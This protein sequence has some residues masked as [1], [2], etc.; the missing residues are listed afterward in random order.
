[1]KVI[2]IN[3]SPRKGWN[4][5]I[6]LEKALEGAQSNGAETQ[7]VNL[8]DLDFKGCIGCLGCK[9]KTNEPR[10]VINDVLKPI[11]DACHTCDAIV[12]GS[13]IYLSEV[14]GELRS[15]IERLLFQY[16]S[17][18]NMGER[19]F[20]GNVKSA[21]IFTTNC[22]E[23]AYDKVG[24]TQLFEG[25]KKV[26]E[27]FYGNCEILAVSETLQTNDYD[28]FRMAMF[29]VPDRQR[30]LREVFPQDCEKAFEIGRRL[31]TQ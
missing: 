10:C 1:M 16:V 17:Y 12:F 28:K 14:T 13:P 18:D 22:P 4:T 29:D 2:A 24:Y 20:T 8:Y 27:R 30:R 11:L 7:M 23:P 31:A 9:L 19:L 25:Y 15:F 6:L 26:M 5:H 3:G 21:F